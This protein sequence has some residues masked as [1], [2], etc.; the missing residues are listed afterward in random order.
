M[1]YVA[2][3]IPRPQGCDHDRLEPRIADM[4]LGPPEQD[5]TVRENVTATA[6]QTE[7]TEPSYLKK[8]AKRL[9]FMTTDKTKLR[10]TAK[11][12]NDRTPA[13]HRPTINVKQRNSTPNLDVRTAYNVPSK[14]KAAD[15][16]CE[17]RSF[18]AFM[19]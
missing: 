5:L 9:D 14:P 15:M 19:H 16:H 17:C 8:V 13:M 10:S 12:S 11:A 4:S 3:E 7:S 18:N 1:S 6:A 2:N